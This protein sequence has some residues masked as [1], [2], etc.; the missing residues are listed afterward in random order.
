LFSDFKKNVLQTP[1]G[2]LSFD[3][4]L[5]SG[6]S[7]VPRGRFALPVLGLS[8]LGGFMFSLVLARFSGRVFQNAAELR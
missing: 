2:R 1:G 6:A 5:F 8:R 3:L 4:G 7:G